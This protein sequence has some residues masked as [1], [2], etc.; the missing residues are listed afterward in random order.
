MMVIM[1]LYLNNEYNEYK[2]VEMLTLDELLKRAEE[3]VVR[4]T[5][6]HI[7]KYKKIP[8]CRELRKLSE[9]IDMALRLRLMCEDIYEKISPIAKE[10]VVREISRFI[11]VYGRPPT[12]RELYNWSELFRSIVDKKSKLKLPPFYD[13]L[14]ELGYDYY[15]RGSRRSNLNLDKVKK[16]L[17]ELIKVYKRLPTF[18]EA[19]KS[20][21]ISKAL[22]R[23]TYTRLLERTGYLLEIIYVV[24]K[25]LEEAKIGR[26]FEKIWEKF[27]DYYGRPIISRGQLQYI[28]KLLK[29]M[30]FVYQEGKRW[31]ITE[32]GLGYLRK[33]EEIRAGKYQD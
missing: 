26:K 30:G 10:I 9:Y 18:E 4:Y 16:D 23:M 13:I 3:D 14:R 15:G 1:A 31:F 21:D 17:D 29:K 11:E 2:M 28:M 20:K 5:H 7:E 22:N 32:K 24:L 12:F 27:K 19:R 33:L 25:T 6:E 8:S